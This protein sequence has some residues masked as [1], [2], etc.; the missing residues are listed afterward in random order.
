MFLVHQGPRHRRLQSPVV[1]DIQFFK[2]LSVQM[3]A[4]FMPVTLASGTLN[5]LRDCLAISSG[6]SYAAGSYFVGV[7]P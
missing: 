6:V 2:E 4:F 5:L 7:L 3:G 1:R